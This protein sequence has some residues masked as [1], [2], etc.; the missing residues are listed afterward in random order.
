MFYTLSELHVPC[1]LVHTC[2]LYLASSVVY[3]KSRQCDSI[4]VAFLTLQAN[5]VI[6]PQNLLDYVLLMSF[7]VNTA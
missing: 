6:L 3:L 7:L 5:T 1:I 4:F 2:A